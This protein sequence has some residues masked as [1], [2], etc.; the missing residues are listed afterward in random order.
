MYEKLYT[1][2]EYFIIQALIYANCV[3]VS[4]RIYSP[5]YTLNY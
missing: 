2:Y 1:V 3:E 4:S 5:A